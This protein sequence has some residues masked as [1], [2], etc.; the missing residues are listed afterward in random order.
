[1]RV[2]LPKVPTESQALLDAKDITMNEKYGQFSFT[3]K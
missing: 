1:M 2:P 3:T